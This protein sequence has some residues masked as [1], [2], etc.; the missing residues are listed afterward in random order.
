MTNS[1]DL[2]LLVVIALC[3]C[4]GGLDAPT[5]TG[6]P[7][8]LNFPSLLLSNSSFRRSK[9]SLRSDPGDRLRLLDGVRVVDVGVLLLVGVFGP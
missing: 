2:H 7:L 4:L 9:T 1:S 5:L 3:L 8:V 6:V